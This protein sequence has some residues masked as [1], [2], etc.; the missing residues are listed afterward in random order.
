MTFIRPGWNT[1]S[2]RACPEGRDYEWRDSGESR[3]TDR[4]VHFGGV[5]LG[6][7]R[8]RQSEPPAEREGRDKRAAPQRRRI[9]RKPNMRAH[10]TCESPPCLPRSPHRRV[11]TAGPTGLLRGLSVREDP[12]RGR[13]GEEGGGRGINFSQRKK[14]ADGFCFFCNCADKMWKLNK[15]RGVGE[16]FI[17]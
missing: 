7:W 9:P 3:G 16:E 5:A 4:Q 11:S 17:P 14:R 2:G 1:A 6:Y 10:D 12:H 15:E 8:F 13:G